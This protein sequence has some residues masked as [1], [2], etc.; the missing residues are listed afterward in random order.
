MAS[1]SVVRRR[2]SRRAPRP[3]GL[4]SGR[5]TGARRSVSILCA[6]IN[7]ALERLPFTRWLHRRIQ[8]G[9]QMP[10]LELGVPAGCEALDGLRIAFVSDVH[11]GSFLNEDDLCAI[12]RRVQAQAPD[13][14]LFGGDL[15]NT[16]ER[17]ILLFRRP[18]AELRPRYGMFAVPGNHDHFFGPDI[19]L[20]RSFLE[21]N[22]V[23]VLCND[24]V[25]IEHRQRSL[26]LC[27]VDDLTEGEPDLRRALAGRREREMA[28][29]LSHHPDFFFE[30]AAVDV[31]L[32]LSGHTHG[33]Q[34][35]VGGKAPLHH[36]KFGYEQGWFREGRSHLYVGRGVG[37]TL[38]PIR[39]DAP[40]EI[41]MVTLRCAPRH[42]GERARRDAPAVACET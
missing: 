3:T 14:V 42:D 31:D 36:S 4:L 7:R 23:R 11:A 28:I 15:I 32:Q 40:P 24:G 6:A 30:A 38:L 17:E 1:R 19:T 2:P 39:I 29:L 25:R 35:R 22:G 10:E 33:G 13:L 16:R 20:W 18:L 12:F 37:V 34:I 27:G 41:P 5:R 9:L 21:E 26:W 8:N